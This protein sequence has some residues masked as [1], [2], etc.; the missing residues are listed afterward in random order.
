[1]TVHFPLGSQKKNLKLERSRIVQFLINNDLATTGH[2]LQGMTKQFLIVSSI[3]YS[4]PNWIYVVLSRVTT[5]DGLFLMH[6]I[7]PNFNPQP[8]KLLQEE[9]VFQRNLEKDTLL[10]LQK[11]GNFP[12]SIDVCNIVST[13][14]TNN[15]ERMVDIGKKTS[16][17][18]K[19][20][21]KSK[22]PNRSTSLGNS[23]IQSSILS[24]FNVWLSLNNMKRI[25]HRTYQYGNCLFESVANGIP[26]WTGKSV[27]LRYSAVEW[28]KIQ[29]TQG[30]IWGKNMWKMFEERKGNSDNY[31][32]SSYLEYLGLL[33]N[34]TIY[35]TEYDIVML[36][37][38]LDMSIYVYT[39]SL[40]V[41]KDGELSC[42]IPM[43]FGENCEREIFL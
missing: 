38:F 24:S 4:T 6:P 28:A 20:T 21:K 1:V 5:L 10:H 11:F 35:G 40:L 12:A 36:C 2:K 37:G 15:M 25:P 43:H 30:T 14:T 39:P 31:G 9:W 16:L 13:I 23:S 29:T 17:P 26:A 42:G 32:K 34:P 22:K 7:K 27:E 41:N 3:N 33:E 19:T 8:T 18:K